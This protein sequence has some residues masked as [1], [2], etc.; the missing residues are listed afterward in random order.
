VFI[1]ETGR[2]ERRFEI[3]DVRER[4]IGVLYYAL[5][6]TEGSAL[7]PVIKEEAQRMRLELQAL[8]KANQ[9]YEL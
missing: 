9:V 1:K 2:S 4:E 5:V 8:M 7:S 6:V 3:R